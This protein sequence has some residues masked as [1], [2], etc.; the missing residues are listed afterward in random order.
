MPEA[1]KMTKPSTVPSNGTGVD[2]F[3]YFFFH[4]SHQ[5]DIS[6]YAQSTCEIF[7]Y[8]NLFRNLPTD[9]QRPG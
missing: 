2:P 7:F 1:F 9:L 5:K 6:P 8:R 3:P 4:S